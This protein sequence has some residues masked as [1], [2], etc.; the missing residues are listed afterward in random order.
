MPFVL[1]SMK[2]SWL[3]HDVYTYKAYIISRFDTNATNVQKGFLSVNCW[4]VYHQLLNSEQI[5]ENGGIFSVRPWNKVHRCQEIEARL[6]AGG[7]GTALQAGIARAWFPI[8]SVGSFVYL[9]FPDA[10]WPLGRLSFWKKRVPGVSSAGKGGRCVGMTT[11][12]PSRPNRWE[13][14]TPG[15]LSASI[16][17]VM[18]RRMLTLLLTFYSLPVTICT[19]SLTFNNCTLCPHCIYVLCI[20]LRTNSDL[21]YLLHK[22]IG[23]YNRDEKFTARY[24][25]C[26]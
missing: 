14:Q 15:D 4:T 22:L 24:A 16:E 6:C 2:I 12:P 3:V 23:F 25:L 26:L 5:L 19:T 17:D 18:K 21:C 11:L 7:W 8:V 9:F 13:P 20:Y 1:N 10:L